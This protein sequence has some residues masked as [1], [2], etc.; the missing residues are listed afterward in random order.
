[1]L[2]LEAELWKLRGECVAP[3]WFPV[4]SADPSNPNDHVALL[5]FH[6]LSRPKHF[7]STPTA[8]SQD[9]NEW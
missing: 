8:I 9:T 7:P 2:G 3:I 1:M 6:P 5:A 4:I